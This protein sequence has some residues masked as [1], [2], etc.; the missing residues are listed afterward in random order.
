MIG[1]FEGSAHPLRYG[2]GGV[3]TFTWSE[4]NLDDSISVFLSKINPFEN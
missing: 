3:V 1:I 4:L 2:V